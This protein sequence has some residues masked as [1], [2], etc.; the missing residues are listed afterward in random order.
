MFSAST[1][2]DVPSPASS[3]A[4]VEARSPRAPLVETKREVSQSSIES[5]EFVV[6][7]EVDIK[8]DVDVDYKIVLDPRQLR[9]RIAALAI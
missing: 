7:E 4:R 8:P 9:G 2:H 5:V 1:A 6:D 3:N